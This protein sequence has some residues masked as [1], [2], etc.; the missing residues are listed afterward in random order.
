MIYEHTI[1]V[2]PMK[3]A[4]QLNH[5][6]HNAEAMMLDEFVQVEKDSHT[7]AI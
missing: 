4:S 5:D 6:R 7:G 1:S 3:I 2:E